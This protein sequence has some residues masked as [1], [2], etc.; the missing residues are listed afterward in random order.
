MLLILAKLLKQTAQNYI[1]FFLKMVGNMTAQLQ[2][3]MIGL[4][5]RKNS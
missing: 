3:L 4:E 1:M 2:K 5:K